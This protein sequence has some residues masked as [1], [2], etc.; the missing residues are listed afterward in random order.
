MKASFII[1]CILVGGF[2]LLFGVLSNDLKTTTT[3]MIAGF[4]FLMGWKRADDH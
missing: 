2:C 1:A 4:F 3:I